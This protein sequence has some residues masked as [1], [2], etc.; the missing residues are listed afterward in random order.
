MKP[1][2][3]HKAKAKLPTIYGTFDIHVF[4]GRDGKEHIMLLKGKPSKKKP[5]L[6]RMHSECLTGDTLASMKCDCGLQLHAALQKIA[7]EGGALVY[8]R[9]EG[10]GIGLANKIKAYA[11]Q[12]KGMDTVEANRKLGFKDDARDYEIGAQILRKMGITKI[13]LLTNNPQKVEGLQN[14]NLDVVERIPLILPTYRASQKYMK[15]KQQKLG[16]LLD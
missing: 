7:K 3:T 8:L 2:I 5:M 14:F 1:I 12:E 10:R 11:L 6:V 13:Q 16:H 9:Q 4:E 15:V